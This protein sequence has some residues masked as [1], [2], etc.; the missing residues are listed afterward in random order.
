[1]GKD[2]D[3][4]A[5]EQGEE[6]PRGK[7]NRMLTLGRMGAKVGLSTLANKAQ[8][9]L[10]IGSEEAR[11]GKLE[12]AYAQNA[13]EV[14]KT[15][16]KLKGASMKVGQL[17]SADPELVP[18]GFSD[19]LSSL[20]S[21]A[22]PMT[23]QTIVSQVEQAF[24]LPMDVVFSYFDP[25]P[26]GAASIGQVHRARLADNDQEVAV[27]IQYPGVVD[28][29]EDD[30]RNLG[31]MMVYARATIN[32]ARLDEYLSEI[33]DSILQEADYVQE[34]QNLAHFHELFQSLPGVTA[35]KPFPKWTRSSILTMEYIQ[36]TKLDDA[37]RAMEDEQQRVALLS[38]W[39]E[40]YTWMFHEQ[41]EMH[42]DPHPGNFFLQADGTIVVLDFGSVKTFDPTFADGILELLDTVW[43]D[44]PERALTIYKKMG[45]AS[46][47]FDFENF[48]P[49]LLAQ[50]HDIVF[51]PFLKDE[52]FDFSDWSPGMQGKTFMLKHPRMLKLVPPSEALPYF[53]MLS[54]VKGLLAKLDAK[55][56]V[57]RLAVETARRRGYLTAEPLIFETI[58]R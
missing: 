32:K 56:N 13:A 1:M 31:S 46:P 36:G 54:G 7:L 29:L 47:S 16:G 5:G 15:L 42:A 23:Y 43:Q 14:V 11:A 17:L 30:L 10:P 34:A 12:Q 2:W 51:A 22:P 58:E 52:P 20:Q 33:R 44:Q 19:M 50:Y 38:R 39:I 28:S 18:E 8:S 57:C 4:L 45:F 49:F 6:V 41:Y 37:L 40:L 9:L 21:S 25:E 35:P 24:D 27:K 48:D 55:V 53:R 26:I 3:K